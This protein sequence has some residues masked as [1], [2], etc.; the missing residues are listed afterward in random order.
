MLLQQT[1]KKYSIRKNKKEPLHPGIRIV[2]KDKLATIQ[3][4]FLVNKFMDGSK[5][6][7]SIAIMLLQTR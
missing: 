1:T 3:S 5:S 4:F 6:Q 7:S 2:T